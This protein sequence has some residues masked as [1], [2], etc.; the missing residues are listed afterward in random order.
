M[1]AGVRPILVVALILAAACGARGQPSPE[2]DRSSMAARDD[3][4]PTGEPDAD[5]DP[6]LA[7]R[8]VLVEQELRGGQVDDPRVFAAMLA[9]PRHRFVP[10]ELRELAYEDRPLP[11]GYDVTISQPFIVALMTQ[12][13]DVQPGERV[14]EVGTG[15]GYQ[16]A[17]LAALGAEVYTIERIGPLAERSASVLA[18]LGYAQ[19][20]VRH[21]GGFL[22]WPE[23]A[24][25]DAIVLTAAPE[26][27]P[28]VLV[29]Q[30]ELGG[31]LVAPI[32]AEHGVQQLVVA[33]RTATGLRKRH[34]VDVAFV[35][36]LPG[37][38][39]NP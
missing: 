31:R 14:L 11:I 15:S 29:D 33:E 19:V 16:A 13:A 34:V 39:E 27:I 7:A 4:D 3:L 35:P 21:G 36:M 1:I 18:E 25:F 28:P 22:G 38:R 6:Y 30:L 37:V 20:H 2:P 5:L 17:V 8:R 9:V 10:V 12:L 26:R 32:G 24:P 23:Q